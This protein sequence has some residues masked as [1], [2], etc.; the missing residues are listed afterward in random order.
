MKSP[1][2]SLIFV[3]NYI[4]SIRP[5]PFFFVYFLTPSFFFLFIFFTTSDSA[6]S[7]SSSF[8]FGIVIVVVIIVVVVFIFSNFIL[9]NFFPFCCTDPCPPDADYIEC[10]PACIPTCMEPSSNCSGSCISGCFCKPGFVFK[11]S[12]CV[13]LEKCGCLD[14]HN[15]YYEVRCPG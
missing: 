4:L 13:P 3:S 2:Q 10:G 9:T 11:G 6:F 1:H 7:S 15:N 8:V 5:S 14:D 12:R